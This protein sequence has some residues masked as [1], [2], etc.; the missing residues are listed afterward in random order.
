MCFETSW[1][2]PSL[3]AISSMMLE[4]QSTVKSLQI[5]EYLARKSLVLGL[6]VPVWLGTLEMATKSCNLR[7]KHNFYYKESLKLYAAAFVIILSLRI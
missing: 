4:E 7:Y 1:N 5:R 3:E 2:R 6:W